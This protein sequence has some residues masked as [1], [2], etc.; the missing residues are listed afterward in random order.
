MFTFRSSKL[1][2]KIQSIS[3]SR[4]CITCFVSLSSVCHSYFFLKTL[5]I[6]KLHKYMFFELSIGSV[7]C[8]TNIHFILLF[9]L[10]SWYMILLM[11]LTFNSNKKILKHALMQQIISRMFHTKNSLMKIK[12]I[13]W[14]TSWL[15][16]LQLYIISFMKLFSLV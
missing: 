7:T 6:P 12:W 1:F 4:V 8:L 3:K 11:V 10:F 15:K 9:I 14:I 2:M 5:F 13:F 16:I